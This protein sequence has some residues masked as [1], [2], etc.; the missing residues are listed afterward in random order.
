MGINVYEGHPPKHV[1]DAAVKPYFM[2]YDLSAKKTKYLDNVMFVFAEEQRLPISI[3]ISS[4]IMTKSTFEN[5]LTEAGVNAQNV[6]DLKWSNSVLAIDSN[7]FEDMSKLSSIIG[8]YNSN[9]SIPSDLLLHM[10]AIQNVEIF[11]DA[12][13]SVGFSLDSEAMN[14]VAKVA[15]AAAV[16]S[17]ESFRNALLKQYSP[18]QMHQLLND[19]LSQECLNRLFPIIA[20]DTGTTYGMLKGPSIDTQY[21]KLSFNDVDFG[22]NLAGGFG[23]LAGNLFGGTFG[24]FGLGGGPPYSFNVDTMTFDRKNLTLTLSKPVKIKDGEG[25]EVEIDSELTIEVNPPEEDGPYADITIYIDLPP[26][27]EAAGRVV[28]G[29][30]NAKSHSKIHLA[31]AIPH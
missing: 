9:T 12:Q 8:P 31:P 29:F 23:S 1:V 18:Y 13:L 30:I 19:V 7:A 26:I 15:Y 27:V 3:D 10:P 28:A 5:A 16:L 11:Q 2:E 24:S 14:L 21:G 6:T 4:D 17:S 22:P 20:I 25:N